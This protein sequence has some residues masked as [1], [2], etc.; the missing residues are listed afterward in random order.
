PDGRADAPHERPRDG[1]RAA[2]A[3]RRAPPANHRADRRRAGVGAR[4]GDGERHERVPHQADRR[5]EAEGSAGARDRAKRRVTL[6]PTTSGSSL[7]LL[8]VSTNIA[9]A[10]AG[11]MGGVPGS[12]TPAG[13]RV[14]G[15]SHV[16]MR[17]VSASRATG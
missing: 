4:A 14:L 16:S 6:H 17:G 3:L 7:T 13:G 2:Q 15:T 11:A 10:I 9:L 1:P 5:A 12:P 8:P